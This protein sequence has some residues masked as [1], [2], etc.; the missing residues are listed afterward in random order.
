MKNGARPRRRGGIA[1]N[2]HQEEMKQVK[3]HQEL[4][5]FEEYQT[6]LKSIRKD[7]KNGMTEKQLQQKYAP[8]AQARIIS[9]MLTNENGAA[10]LAA[11]KDLLDR[12]N[13]KAT[14][15]K[16]VSHRFADMSDTELDAVLKSEEADLQDM[17]QRFE[18]EQ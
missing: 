18:T 3:L 15:K 14:E 4:S 16:E 12:V 7:I 5:Q 13:G 17:E 8:L 6:I 1:R 9:E 2:G 10:A 11:A